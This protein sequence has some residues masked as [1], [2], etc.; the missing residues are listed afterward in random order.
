MLQGV[1][2]ALIA[3]CTFG[4]IPLFTLPLLQDG[5]TTP[6]IIF[7]RFF[8][9]SITMAG[10]LLWKRLPLAIP[11]SDFRKLAVLAFSYTFGASTFFLSFNYINSGLATTLH[12]GYP[13]VVALIMIL[14]YGEKATISTGVSI[15]MAMAGVG[16]LLL[17]GNASGGL[18]VFGV[19]IAIFSSLLYGIYIVGIQSAKL[20]TTNGMTITFHLILLG[21]GYTF[22]FACL[23]GS[24]QIPTTGSEWTNLFL[25]GTI[26]TI[27]SNLALVA[28]VQRIGSTLTSVLGVLEPVTAVAI[29]ALFFQEVLTSQSF[30]GGLMILIAVFVILAAPLF[31][32]KK[33]NSSA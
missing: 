11:R 3:A 23:Q 16:T 29:G 28:A 20:I 4:T 17:Q 32:K 19:S 15:F 25:L 22:I 33:K 13:L 8:I 14:R 18:S 26:T 10:V 21:S 5:M 2:L 7:Y 31:S 6:S 12:F 1:L 9:A 30:L 24:L 27:L